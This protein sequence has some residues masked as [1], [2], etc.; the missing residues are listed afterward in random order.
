MTT[1]IVE[2]DVIIN[3]MNVSS[4]KILKKKINNFN[5]KFADEEKVEQFFIEN[6]RY[7]AVF[8]MTNG[9]KYNYFSPEFESQEVATDIIRELL[10]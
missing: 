8:T 10:E 7:Y 4:V 1:L 6:G 3:L 9:D 5:S 2:H